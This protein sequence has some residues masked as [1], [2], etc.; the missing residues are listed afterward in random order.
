MRQCTCPQAFEKCEAYANM[1]RQNDCALAGETQ[2]PDLKIDCMCNDSQYVYAGLC[3]V[4]SKCGAYGLSLAKRYVESYCEEWKV[5]APAMETLKCATITATST[6]APKSTDV[7]SSNSVTESKTSV[8]ATTH[9]SQPSN[10]SDTGAGTRPSVGLIAGIASG[11][12]ILL[13]TVIILYFC[14]FKRKNNRKCS[15]PHSI[16]S[17]PVKDSTLEV[18]QMSTFSST[19]PLS[20]IESHQHSMQWSDATGGYDQ[21]TSG[22]SHAGYFN[23]TRLDQHTTQQ[24][25]PELAGG[26]VAPW[27]PELHGSSF[28]NANPSPAELPTGEH[29]H[30]QWKYHQTY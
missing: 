27:R 13:L 5:P 24:E 20:S 4:S 7:R 15:T 8:L 19:K 10:D 26:Q 30:R 28:F 22:Y 23:S 21:Q 3:C 16:S 12:A 9:S 14:W 2:C 6:T 1:P 18:V 29:G 11:I 25:R 17:L